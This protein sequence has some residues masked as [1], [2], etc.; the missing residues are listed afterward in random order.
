MKKIYI[1]ALAIGAFTFSSVQAQVDQT[2][3]LESYSSGPIASQSDLW[4]TWTGDEGGP[5][6]GMVTSEQ[7]N[8]GSQSLNIVQDN[9]NLFLIESQPDSGIYSM[10]FS[11]Y[12]PEG[13]EGYFNV[14]GQ[15]PTT[16]G[17][18]L[19][20]DIYF[21]PNN[22]TPGQGQLGDGSAVWF[23]PH[24]AWFNIN[25]V[26]DMDD[27]SYGMNV[28]GEIAIPEGTP[29]NDYI[30]P[31]VGAIDFFGPSEFTNYFVDDFVTAYGLLG[32]DDV[33][34]NTF[35]VYPNPVKDVLNI[36]TKTS[37]DNV[38]IYDILGKVVLQA[39]PGKISPAISTSSL[40]TG[41]YLVKIT[42]GSTS[43]TIKILK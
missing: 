25:L 28:D 2:D 20:G 26:V 33:S 43:K 38:T 5:E 37:V 27:R 16:T 40:A 1:L 23:F 31:Y 13:N 10:Q 3:D 18:F 24:D 9:D 15:M 36:Q 39:N 29:F 14:Q 12:I 7:A 21:N 35:S 22:E 6:D 17:D 8:S 11:M 41:S 34:E 32:V 30:N 42:S 4:T 19:S